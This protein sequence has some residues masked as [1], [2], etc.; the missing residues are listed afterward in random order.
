[1]QTSAAVPP[2]RCT[3]PVGAKFT[4]T[5]L[6]GDDVIRFRLLRVI[7]C[8]RKEW[9][10]QGLLIANEIIENNYLYS[11]FIHAP[12]PAASTTPILFKNPFD[13]Q[14]Q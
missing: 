10:L 14:I 11:L 4:N 1:M 13:A 9:V 12:E 6:I 5:G 7:V 2:F 3:T 8:A